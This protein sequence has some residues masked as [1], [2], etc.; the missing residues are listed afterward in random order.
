[1]ILLDMMMPIMDGRE[2]AWRIRANP[3]TN[4]IPI[5]ARTALSRSD[6]LKACLLWGCNAY[7]VKRFGVRNLQR[8]IENC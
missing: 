6:D 4:G 1:M 7:M 8:N 5:L 3:E 2:L